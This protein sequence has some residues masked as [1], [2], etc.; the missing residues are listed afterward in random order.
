MLLN[1]GHQPSHIKKG[2]PCRQYCSTRPTIIT[3]WDPLTICS[4]QFYSIMSN[5]LPHAKWVCPCK[6]YYLKRYINPPY[7]KLGYPCRRYHST[8]Y[9][10]HPH[11]KWGYPC[12]WYYLTR[13]IN[14]PHVKWDIPYRWH[15][16]TRCT[17]PHCVK[18]GYPCILCYLTKYI[19][20]H[21]KWG[22]HIDGII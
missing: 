2:Y 3:Q 18:W 7:A 17:K 16:L 9:I 8:R 14:P 5:I 13:Y 11:V 4:R 1:M 10:K 21:V 15:Y 19:N 22:Y 6:W 20:P 12:R